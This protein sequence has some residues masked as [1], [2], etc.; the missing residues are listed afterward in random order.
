[1]IEIKCNRCDEHLVKT[2]SMYAVATATMNEEKSVNA[3]FDNLMYVQAA[4][5]PKCTEVSFFLGKE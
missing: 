1:M 2:E 5:C 4:Y 3:S